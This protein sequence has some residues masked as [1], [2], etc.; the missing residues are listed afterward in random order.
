MLQDKANSAKSEF[1][2]QTLFKVLHHV[3]HNVE[4]VKLEKEFVELGASLKYLDLLTK[5]QN[6]LLKPV[7]GSFFNDESTKGHPVLA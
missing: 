1:F 5:K 2:D 4:S 7:E 6:D 3:V